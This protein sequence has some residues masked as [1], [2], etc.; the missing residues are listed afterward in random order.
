MNTFKEKYSFERRLEISNKFLSS[1]PNK[2][3]IIVNI[4]NDIKISK[5]KFIFDKNQPLS[6]FIINLRKFLILK[7]DE[8]IF[9][10]INNILPSQTDLISSLYNKYKDEDGFIYLT[11]TKESTFG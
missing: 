1:Y 11:V 5:N 2:I 10:F 6:S 8:A 3:P 7:Q 9:I 4:Q